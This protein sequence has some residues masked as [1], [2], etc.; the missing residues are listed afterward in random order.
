MAD[1]IT[2]VG[3]NAVAELI[4]G[5]GS[6]QNWDQLALGTSGTAAS[7]TQT[8]LVSELTGSGLAK[9]TSTVTTT[10][11]NV[12]QLQHTWTATAPKTLQEVGVFNSHTATD[13]VM[14]ARS[15]FADIALATNDQIQVTYK[16]TV[17]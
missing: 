6:V 1:K 9:A 4:G 17:S 14:L 15:D 3:K 5:I 12:L 10:T 8:A 7:S 16:V 13:G 2:T 11:A